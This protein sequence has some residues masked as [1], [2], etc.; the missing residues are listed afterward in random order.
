M[1]DPLDGLDSFD[2]LDGMELIYCI[3]WMNLIQQSTKLK[4]GRH[5]GGG[6]S[7]GFGPVPDV[8][9]G[10]DSFHQLDGVELI[11]FIE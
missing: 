7:Q 9:D 10:L 4:L 11:Y 8:L 3:E 6:L 5:G 1:P 2:Q